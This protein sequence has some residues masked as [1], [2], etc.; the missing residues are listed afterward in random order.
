MRKHRKIFFVSPFLY[1]M[2]HAKLYKEQGLWI[3]TWAIIREKWRI[4][5]YLSLLC[6]HRLDHDLKLHAHEARARAGRWWLSGR[7]GRACRACAQGVNKTTTLARAHNRRAA[8]AFFIN[9]F[10]ESFVLNSQS[11]FKST[12]LGM[13]EC[14][15][16]VLEL[17]FCRC[18]W[19]CKEDL[20][21]DGHDQK[22][23]G[24]RD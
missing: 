6:D 12:V 20:D 1:F 5:V 19:F 13:K 4:C 24:W 15:L 17:A 22:Y 18:G 8:R 21:K 9:A 16:S 7:V 14:V 2:I 11:E 23:I 3:S 10:L